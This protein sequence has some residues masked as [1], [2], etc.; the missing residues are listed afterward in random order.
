MHLLIMINGTEPITGTAVIS[1]LTKS[2]TVDGIMRSMPG[3]VTST[4][5]V[6]TTGPT[7][8]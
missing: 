2:P 8:L 3:P 5:G 6:G 1:A 7:K 4:S